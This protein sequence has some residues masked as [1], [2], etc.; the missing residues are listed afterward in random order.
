MKSKFRNHLIEVFTYFCC[1]KLTEF[2]SIPIR[3]HFFKRQQWHLFLFC[4]V[5]GQLLLPWH[6]YTDPFCILRRK[7]LWNYKL[8]TNEQMNGRS[9]FWYLN[10]H[11][12]IDDEIYLINHNS[13]IT[14]SLLKSPLLIIWNIHLKS[15]NYV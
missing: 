1:F 12:I 5:T 15:I 10:Y 3:R 4:T 13:H 8:E 2:R 14:H 7:K 9:K 11:W 6:S